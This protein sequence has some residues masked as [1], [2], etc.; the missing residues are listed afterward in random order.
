MKLTERRRLR[1]Q[2][3]PH[4]IELG[5]I[6]SL[7][8]CIAVF[9]FWP[10]FSAERKIMY[11]DFIPVDEVMI[12]D[13]M[14]TRQGIEIPPPP[15][16]N[17]PPV[18]VPDDIIVDE[19]FDFDDIFELEQEIIAGLPDL[20][21]DDQAIV[22]NP[23]LPANV[24]RIVEPVVPAEFREQNIRAQ[25]VV[26]FIVTENGSVEDASINEIRLFNKNKGE[27]ELVNFIGYGI[28]DATIQ[29]AL[30][31]RFRPA[32]NQGESVRTLARHTFSFGS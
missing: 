17:V 21:S 2:V 15:P 16:V 22:M 5:I 4:R 8:I 24:S 20:E 26:T 30:R 19:E 28:E 1:D 3:Y 11:Q 31:W 9:R 7:L 29:A 32:M 18:P 13:V 12:D 14:V 10:D 6:I 25:I 27:F 23:Q